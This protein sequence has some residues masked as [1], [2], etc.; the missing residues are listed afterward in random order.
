MA[1]RPTA[2]TIGALGVRQA[3]VIDVGVQDDGAMEIPP[4]DEVGWYRYGAA[5]GGEGSAILAAHIA[6][7][8]EDGV[9]VDLVELG[10]GAEVEVALDDG[11][12]SRYVV[13]STARY[14][15]DAL[16]EEVVFARTGPP[17]LVLVTCGGRFDAE[18]RSYDDNVVVTAI[19]LADG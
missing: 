17:R 1:P 5:P 13:E 2:L 8:G 10:P 12:T 11:T 4:V 3:P 16:P 18:A 19:P 6:Y 9:F 15:K 14:P 7:D